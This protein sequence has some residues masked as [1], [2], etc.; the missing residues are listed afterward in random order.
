MALHSISFNRLDGHAVNGYFFYIYHGAELDIDSEVVDNL[1]KTTMRLVQI[2]LENGV[3][4]IDELVAYPG[5]AQAARRP[6]EL[7]T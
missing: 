1:Q 6:S 5:D 7:S 4:T 2:A 3:Y